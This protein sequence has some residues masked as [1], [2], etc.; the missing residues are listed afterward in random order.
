MIREDRDK[1][2]KTDDEERG[3]EVRRRKRMKGDR[4]E[5]EK[6]EKKGGYNEKGE[7]YTRNDNEAAR[8]K[9]KEKPDK[10]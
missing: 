4:G 1:R 8:R 10:R 7:R 6:I 9:E 3:N 5:E 2:R